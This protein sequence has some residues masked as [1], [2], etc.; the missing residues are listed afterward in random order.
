MA[1]VILFLAGA[2]E[3]GFT[4]FMKM[5]EGFTRPIP[6]V[7]FAICAV[8]SFVFL[9]L[10]VRTI[11][12]GSAYAVWTGL[13]AVGTIA[14]GISVFGEDRSPLRLFFLALIVIGVLGVKATTREV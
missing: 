7:A 5:S 4:T 12:L 2:F 11:P 6:A 1:W 13:G 10:A 3:V 14:I 8:L 9:A